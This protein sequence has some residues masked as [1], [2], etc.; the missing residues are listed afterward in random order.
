ME[1]GLS[2]RR[3]TLRASPLLRRLPVCWRV[4]ATALLSSPEM[5]HAHH[6][7]SAVTS[8]SLDMAMQREPNPSLVEKP[9]SHSDRRTK[10][11]VKDSLQIS[12]TLQFPRS[13]DL[14]F[15]C[16]ISKFLPSFIFSQWNKFLEVQMTLQRQEE[17]FILLS[18][19]FLE[20][21]YFLIK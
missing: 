18:N 17:K 9:L 6:T 16:I 12:S 15:F 10:S 21:V 19:Y 2:G 20:K 3:P 11:K 8:K 13:V 14:V 1:R 7:L 4:R 5:P